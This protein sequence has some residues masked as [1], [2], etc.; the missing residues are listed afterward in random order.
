[1]REDI[2]GSKLSTDSSNAAQSISAAT[3]SF[4]TW[5]TD[6]MAHLDAA[7]AAD[8]GFGLPHAIKGL[9]LFGM[10][11][12]D[13]YPTAAAA[14]EAA[15][16]CRPASTEREGRYVSALDA[17]LCGRITEATTHYEAIAAETPLDLL[18]LRLSQF[19][20]FWIGEVAWMRDISERAASHWSE[21][22]PSYS[23]FQALRSFGLEENGEYGL[24]EAIGKDSIARDPSDC[25]GAHA[26]AHVLIMQGRLDDGV[27]W[28][29]GLTGNWQNANHIVHHLWWH[30]A[31][32]YAER[33]DYSSALEI[34]DERLRNLDS[35]LMKAIPDL[36]IDIQNDISILSRLEL[37]GVDV[38]DRWQPLADL[39][40]PR[41]GNHASPF[42]SAHCV[43]ALSRAGCDSDAL[44]TIQRIREFISTDPGTLAAR[45]SLAAL[46]A[47]EAAYAHCRGEFENVIDIIMPARRNLWQMG[48]SHAQRDLFFQLAADAALKAG[49][50]DVLRLLFDDFDG[51]G[52]EHLSE[53]SSYA[54]ALA[55][56][57]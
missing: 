15:R 29:E 46:P 14:L 43:I 40:R 19:E 44:E 4:I 17:C 54:D 50:P 32:F 9:L 20:L 7:I 22:I 55:S 51:F 2:W 45:Y 18:A 37:R 8:P 56:L 26:V 41:I 23:A 42:T 52:L 16:K 25:W 57:H 53:R 5:R 13:H 1:M 3:S 11:N 39:A 38:G 10:R 36:Y 34:F 6:T 31:L 49:R 47:S 28:I 33:G 12:P 30:L 21:D 24:A 35:P 27:H 48:G